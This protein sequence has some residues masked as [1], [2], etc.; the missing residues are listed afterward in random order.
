MIPEHID[1]DDFFESI[2]NQNRYQVVI[3]QDNDIARLDCDNLEEAKLV[4]RSFVNYGKCQSVTIEPK[5]RW[6]GARDRNGGI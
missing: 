1:N 3:V 6:G 5:V 4:Q 2:E